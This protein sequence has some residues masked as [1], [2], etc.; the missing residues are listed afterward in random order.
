[1]VKSLYSN[2]K[3]S[4]LICCSIVLLF[5]GCSKS[6]APAITESK[7]NSLADMPSNL[8]FEDAQL[9]G[10]RAHGWF[11][12][13]KQYTPD[14][15]VKLV[16]G[17]AYK[18][19]QCAELYS[20][21]KPNAREF[22]NIM[23]AL[24]AT[25]FRGKTIR[26]RGAVRVGS[27]N[28][29][30]AEMWMRVDRPHNEM[31]FFDNMND[32]PITSTEWKEYEITGTVDTDAIDIYIGCML[33]GEGKANFDAVTVDIVDSHPSAS[34]LD[35]DRNGWGRAGSYPKE[36]RMDIL[37]GSDVP[38]PNTGSNSYVARI[39]YIAPGEPSG[40]GTFMKMYPPGK[41]AGK[42]LKMTGYIKTE[43]VTGWCGMWC[44]IDGAQK[45]NDA[46]QPEVMDF[47]NMQDRPIIGTTDWKK[48]EI[49][50]NIPK[51]ASYIAYGVLLG[52]KGTAY[53]KNIA[54]EVL[55]EAKAGRH[56][57]EK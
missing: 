15:E 16:S 55:G 30:S 9:G 4:F 18:G 1:M 31:G 40:F 46:E 37:D 26:F 32:R 41:W 53:F 7:G 33:Q 34:L 2:V 20:T 27:A 44:R 25:P 10:G 48:Y 39:E 13:Q 21:G 12:P 51:D 28:G 52:G 22:G 49:T 19:K 14:Y 36:Y 17:G 54:F 8:D 38:S 56:R 5:P 11:T 57:M 29:G 35:P 42:E 6:P 43:N 3:I 47:D 24:D 50:V 45:M 23:Q